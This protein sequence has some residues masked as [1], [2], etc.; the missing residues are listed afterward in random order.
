[1]NVGAFK[2]ITIV[3]TVTEER[4]GPCNTQLA[5][6]PEASVLVHSV[7]VEQLEE[8]HLLAVGTEAL[9]RGFGS[10]NSDL[11][12]E[13]E[14]DL[15][16]VAFASPSGELGIGSVEEQRCLVEESMSV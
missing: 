8:E 12:V 10:N 9:H 15:V 13:L 7:V 2:Y 3:F 16:G 4:F 5:G 11:M 6:E 1:L 14:R